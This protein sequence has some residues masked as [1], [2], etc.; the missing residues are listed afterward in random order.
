MK[1]H[2]VA[3]PQ[4]SRFGLQQKPNTTSHPENPIF[5]FHPDWD[6]AVPKSCKGE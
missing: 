2:V 6:G 3:T 5:E 1:D 4:G